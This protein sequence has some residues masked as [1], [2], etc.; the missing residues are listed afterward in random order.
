MGTELCRCTGLCNVRKSWLVKSCYLLANGL[1]SVGKESNRPD[2][3]PLE[4]DRD[5]GFIFIWRRARLTF[6]LTYLHTCMREARDEL[7]DGR[8]TVSLTCKA[9]FT[10]IVVTTSR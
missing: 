9:K 1:F 7:K 5:S 10:S 6:R 8:M 2:R 3:S 4:R